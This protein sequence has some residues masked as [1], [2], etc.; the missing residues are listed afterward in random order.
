MGI[1]CMLSFDGTG[2]Y[3][4]PEDLWQ[5]MSRHTC[6]CDFNGLYRTMAYCSL[7]SVDYGVVDRWF[8]FKLCW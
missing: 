6:V 1:R 7:E 8:V 4:S 2:L 3:I 5:G